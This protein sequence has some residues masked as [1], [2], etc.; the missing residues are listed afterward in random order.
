MIAFLMILTV[1]VV[2]V[3]SCVSD[4]RTMRIPNWHS[5]VIVGAFAVAFVTSPSSFGAW[6]EHLGAFGLMFA[7]TFL[8]SY[9]N[10]FGAGDA[11]FASVLALWLGFKGLFPYMFYMT[12]AGG[13]LAVIALYLIRAKPVTNPASGGWVAQAQGDKRVVPYGI[14]ISVGAWAAFFHTGLIDRTLHEVLNL[15]H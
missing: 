1:L 6:W 4:F 14:G 11:K 2:T 10:M 15:I 9:K 5:A 12:L 7:V 13:V 3:A 8:M